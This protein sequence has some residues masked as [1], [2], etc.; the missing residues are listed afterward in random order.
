MHWAFLIFIF[1]ERCQVFQFF[2]N[3]LSIAAT[4][5]PLIYF[6]KVTALLRKWKNKFDGQDLF[7]FELKS[8]FPS[9]SGFFSAALWGTAQE[10]L[11]VRSKINWSGYLINILYSGILLSV[12]LYDFLIVPHQMIG[13]NRYISETLVKTMG[14]FPHTIFKWAL[15]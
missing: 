4:D 10:R 6:L 13:H 3:V 2:W 5:I 14:F 11:P 7:C 8:V 15:I 1:M 9:L 12:L